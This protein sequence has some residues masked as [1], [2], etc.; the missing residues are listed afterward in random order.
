MF[1]T[2]TRGGVGIMAGVTFGLVSVAAAAGLDYTNATRERHA[3]QEAADAAVLAAAALSDVTD[4]E[5]MD[6]AKEMFM[7]S[8]FCSTKSCKDPIVKIDGDAVSFEGYAMIPTS[9][10]QIAGVPQ[11]EVGAMSKAVPATETPLDVVMILDYSGSMNGSNKYQDMAAAA[12]QF[13]QSAEDQPGDNMA[14]GVVPFS[15]YVLT[16][17]HGRYLFDVISGTNLMGKPVVGCILNREHPYSTN[18]DEPTTT[19]QGSLWPVFGY[20]EAGTSTFTD[21]YPAVDPG[22]TTTGTYTYT[23]NSTVFEYDLTFFNTDPSVSPAPTLMANFFFDANGDAISMV[24]DARNHYVL[25]VTPLNGMAYE[26]VGQATPVLPGA[27]DI[28][29]GYGSSDSWSIGDD[30][31]LPEVFNQDLLAESLPGTCATYASNHLLSK[32][33]T[34]NFADLKTSVAKMEPIGLTNIALGLDLGWHMLTP[35]RPFKEANTEDGTKKIAILLTDGVQTVSAHGNGGAVSIASANANIAESCA[36]MKADGVEI[37]TIA[38][39]INDAYTRDLLKQCATAEPN[40]FEPNA[41]GDL[42]AVFE[43]IFDKLVSGQV[44][45]TG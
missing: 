41:G 18:A 33:L 5:R 43:G 8:T 3:L 42:D 11:I 28:F 1:K 25:T 13:I 39:G 2:D 21:P 6:K 40:Y 15:E 31:G 44:R 36:A 24:F 34:Q 7:G 38:F 10:L 26:V 20:A 22:Q 30:S 32:P 45:L 14:V 27:F 17:M 37:F 12:T 16:P 4:R 29:G 19:T 23:H 35:G 9:L